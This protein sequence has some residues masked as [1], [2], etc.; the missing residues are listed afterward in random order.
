M[1]NRALGGALQGARRAALVALALLAACGDAGER[2]A[3]TP[4]DSTKGG[5]PQQGGTAVVAEGGA[6]NRPMPLLVN[7]LPDGDMLDVMYMSLV[8][9]TWRDGRL[10][11]RLSD[12]SPM[13]LARQY[14]YTGPDSTAIR[15]RLRGG[16][17]WSDGQPITAHDV[18][19]T[20]NTVAD[21]RAASPQSYFTEQMDS[22]RA[23]ND[24]TVV[25]YFKRRHPGMLFEAALNIAPRHAYADTPLDQL[26]THPVFGNLENL[27]VSGAFKVG[28]HQRGQQTV[29][30]PNPYFP[31]KPRLDRIVM[32]AI[33]DNTARF[34]ELQ[35]GTVDFARGAQYDVV[36][37]LRQ[38]VPAVRWEREEDRFW[39]FVAYNAKTVP[40]FADP[41]IRRALGMAIDVPG[42]IQRLRMAEFTT[43]AAGPYPPIFRDLAD[44][45]LRPLAFDTAGARRILE[46]EG[47]RDTDGDGIREKNGKPFR[48]TLMTNTGNQRRQDVATILQRQWR[49]VGVDVRVQMYE[50]ATFFDHL[51]AKRDYQAALGS[52]QV[53]LTPDLTALWTSEGPYN[54][55]GYANPEVDSMIARARAQPTAQAANPRWR[56]AA[57]RIVQDQPYTM[58]YYYDPTTGVSPRLRGTTVNSYGAYQ[59]TWEWWVTGPP[60]RPGAADT[61]SGGRK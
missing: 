13:A 15:F 3:E 58:L 24:S 55:V 32:R 9:Q 8:S 51:I 38:R 35:N 18:A 6:L 30:V 19:W 27:V 49:A 26:N 22:V 56:A 43:Q 40:Q 33:P 29:L 14:E 42:I 57:A 46:Q 2:R 59:N 1:K 53:G 44:P 21:P 25:L 23:E 45:G 10:V 50:L 7:S 4:A 60:A 20:Y 5:P 31:V 48:F 39:E 61:S 41:D 52:W 36:D 34:V 28:S 54:I 11:S 17:R 47:W 37:E 12:E 16:L